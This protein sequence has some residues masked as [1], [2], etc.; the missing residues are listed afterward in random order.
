MRRTALLRLTAMFFHIVHIFSVRAE[1]Y[2]VCIHKTMH[3][4]QVYSLNKYLR[5][6]KLYI[7]VEQNESVCDETKKVSFSATIEKSG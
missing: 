2:C 5:Y 7:I 4:L 3:F 1:N 6:E